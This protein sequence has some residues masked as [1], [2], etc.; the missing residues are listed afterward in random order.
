MINYIKHQVKKGI[1]N[2]KNGKNGAY[3]DR[4]TISEVTKNAVHRQKPVF[5]IEK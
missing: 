5:V 1:V 3:S 2:L 4:I